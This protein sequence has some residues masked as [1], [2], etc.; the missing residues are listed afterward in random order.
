M[1][2]IY[3]IIIKG[4][5]GRYE[6]LA[7]DAI[8]VVQNRIICRAKGI[9]RK[10]EIAPLPGDRV[11]V[12]IQ[13]DGEGLI[14]AIEPRK[15]EFVRPKV[16]NVDRVYI[17]TSVRKPKPDLAY[18]DRLTV[19]CDI[20]QVDCRLIFNKIDLK[21]ADEYTAL[22]QAA[23][24]IVHAVSALEKQNLEAVMVELPGTLSCFAGFS[25]VGK[26]ELLSALFG[27]RMAVSADVSEKLGRG[28]HTTRTVELFPLEGVDDLTLIGD[29]PGFN[30]VE[31]LRYEKLEWDELAEHF[32][33]FAPLLGKCKYGGCT[34]VKE[35]GCAIIEAVQAGTIATSRH[36]SYLKMFE[37]IKDYRTWQD[38]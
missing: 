25:G 11:L 17:V 15:N 34:H 36:E 23:G 19:I 32:R 10:D 21:D 5:G 16:S 13:A 22:Y 8:D 31:L 28:R 18:I 12:E 26:S 35:D 7:D 4:V 1:K 27:K 38:K 6:I 24:F 9:F 29:T 3:G 20:K 2:E 14:T 33:E 30:V 37:E